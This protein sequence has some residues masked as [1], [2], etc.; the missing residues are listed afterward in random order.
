MFNYYLFSVFFL[1]INCLPNPGNCQDCQAFRK[2]KLNPSDSISLNLIESGDRFN[3]LELVYIL[4]SNLALNRSSK[5]KYSVYSLITQGFYLENI[6]SLSL[7][8][9]NSLD[10]IIKSDTTF[11]RKCVKKEE[12]VKAFFQKDT[13]NQII[14]K[15]Y[16]IDQD[17]RKLG[18]LTDNY[19]YIGQ[20]D[21]LNQQIIVD[22]LLN[23]NEIQL[24]YKS[25]D[26]LHIILL[27]LCRRMEERLFQDINKRLINLV[28]DKKFNPVSYAMIYDERLR[29]NQSTEYPKYNFLGN[30]KVD[31]DKLRKIEEAR[32]QINAF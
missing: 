18:K 12:E 16:N 30:E 3:I 8:D 27:H 9:K 24:S 19:N 10:K 22:V 14:E 28:L 29:I 13:I 1:L 6:Y 21:S 26:H 15:V 7:I 23:L 25:Q 4:N 2:I 5:V 20:I 11:F 17:S 32:C 31:D